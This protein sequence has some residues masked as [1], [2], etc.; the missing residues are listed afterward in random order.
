MLFYPLMHSQ[1]L[2]VPLRRLF[3]LACGARL[4]RDTYPAGNLFDLPFLVIGEYTTIGYQS[5]LCPHLSTGKR[6]SHA[7]I[8]IG[9]NV[10]IG[11]GAMIYGGAVVGDGAIISAG[12]ILGPYVVVGEHAAVKPCSYVKAH[13][14]VAPGET[15]S[16][17]PAAVESAKARLAVPAATP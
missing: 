2:P 8:R 17:A 15:W 10:T 9:S 13:T 6:L 14:H 3:F 16:G 5:V 7:R 11:A 1:L 12:A 4:G